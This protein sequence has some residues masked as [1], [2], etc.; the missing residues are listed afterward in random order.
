[1]K[2]REKILP[3]LGPYGEDDDVEAVAESVLSGWW[4]KGPRVAE[5]EEKFAKLVGSKYAV[6]VNSNSAGQDLIMKALGM[7]GVDVINPTISF[8]ATAVIPLWNDCSTNIVDVTSETLNIDPEDVEKYKKSNSELLIAVNMAGI[9]AP[10]DDI[11]TKFGGFI[12]EDCAHSC[13]VQGAGTLGDIA[14]WSFQAVKTLPCGD[15]GMITTNDENLYRKLTDMTWFGIPSTYSRVGKKGAGG[16]TWDYDVDILGYKCYMID[17][18]AALALSQLKKLN[19]S[20]STR[21]QIQK[22]YNK[23][24]SKF[25]ERP[26][27]SDTVQYYVARVP[28]SDRNLLIDYLAE[29]NI[30]TSVHF[31]PLHLHK[32]L[33]QERQYPQADSIWTQLISFPCHAGMTEEDIEYVIYWVNKYFEEKYS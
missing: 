30:H 1:M 8:L 24:L 21:L 12:L 31:K 15:G 3:V 14:V 25:V 20:L 18:Q 32:L 2:I 10:I 26:P 19:K 29:K 22:S 9:P 33:K 28:T 27:H 7:K 16:Y 5:F 6:A 17:L 13:Y 23:N 4:G 11:R